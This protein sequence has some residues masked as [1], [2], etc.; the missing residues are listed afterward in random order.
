MIGVESVIEG[1]T[2]T[3]LR[4]I[5]DERGAVLHMLRS[6]S[7]DFTRFGECYFSEVLPGAVKAWKRHR[8]Q[9]QNLAVPVGRVRFVIYDDRKL[10]F[11]RNKLQI[12]ELGRPDNYLRLRI[13]PGLWYG[14]TCISASAALIANCPDFPH[15]PTESEMCKVNESTIPYNWELLG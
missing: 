7:S 14:F 6:D 12:F 15:D 9:T 13:P 5:I 11:T 1:V 4:Q 3:E 2:L 8:T 10:S